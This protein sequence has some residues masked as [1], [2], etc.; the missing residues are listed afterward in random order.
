MVRKSFVCLILVGLSLL[1]LPT[2]KP[3]LGRM[4][5]GR[6]ELSDRLPA[7][8]PQL[9]VGSLFD[10]SVVQKVLGRPEPPNNWQMIP[11]WYAG[12]WEAQ[13]SE[14][15]R[16]VNEDTGAVDTTHRLEKNVERRQAGALYT[17][18]HY[19]S[20]EGNDFWETAALATTD[21]YGY[22]LKFEFVLVTPNM[23]VIRARTVEFNVDRQSHKVLQVGQVEILERHEKV[24]ESHSHDTTESRQYS[25]DG[26]P[27]S[28]VEFRGDMYKTGPF[29]WRVSADGVGSSDFFA[30]YCKEHHLEGE[31]EGFLTQYKAHQESRK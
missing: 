9:S 27:T 19:W 17:G 18:E 23:V 4:L 21:A 28:T 22:V 2:T 26:L 25:L 15:V 24:T 20:F 6:V 30:R 31:L 12:R 29:E 11:D 1:S 10:K 13:E 7:L 8:D 3:A 14:T 5:E 16:S